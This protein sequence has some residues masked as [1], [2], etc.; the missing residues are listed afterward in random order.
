MVSSADS[1]AKLRKHGSG[2][3]R[4]RRFSLYCGASAGNQLEYQS[5]QG[6]DEQQ[7]NESTHGVAAHYPNQPQNKKNHK[8]CPKHVTLAFYVLAINLEANGT[9]A[10]V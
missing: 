6:Q 10:V 9:G 7:M 5:Y 1:K 2:S 3:F 8:N 4:L